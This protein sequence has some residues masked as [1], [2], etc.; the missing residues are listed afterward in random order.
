MSRN[1]RS[2]PVS[3]KR[4]MN[5]FVL[6]QGSTPSFTF[7]KGWC[8]PNFG[9][10]SQIKIDPAHEWS[11]VPKAFSVWRLDPSPS[12]LPPMQRDVCKENWGG[13]S[14]NRN[15]PLSRR[16]FKMHRH[17][18]RYLFGSLQFK[19]LSRP[20]SFLG[21]WSMPLLPISLFGWVFLFLFCQLKT[22]CNVWNANRKIVPL[23][24][25]WTATTKNKNKNKKTHV[26]Y[27]AKKTEQKKTWTY[28]RKHFKA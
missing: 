4:Q 12:P 3:L 10:L 25:T 13:L 6:L 18:W 7:R 24:T 16:R 22:C 23:Q 14:I 5:S 27:G 26:L 8:C 15:F 19:V 28:M 1:N 11:P 9:R 2:A 20:T 17:T 21:Y